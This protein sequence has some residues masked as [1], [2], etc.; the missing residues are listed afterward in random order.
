MFPLTDSPTELCTADGG[1][2][3]YWLNK[4][5]WKMDIHSDALPAEPFVRNIGTIFYGLA[6]DSKRSEIYVADAI[7]YQQQGMVYRYS[8]QGE[9]L[10]TFYV[11]VIPGFIMIQ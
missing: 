3:L 5:V 11:G 7:D 2:T 4:D 6:I 1:N 9:I 10:D 8:S